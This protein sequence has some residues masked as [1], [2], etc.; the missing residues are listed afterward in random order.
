[1]PSNT[2]QSESNAVPKS[3]KKLVI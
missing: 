1:V 3:A 2:Q